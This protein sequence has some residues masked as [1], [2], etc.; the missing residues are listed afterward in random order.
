M[1]KNINMPLVSIIIP[2]YNGERFMRE[3]IDSA[4]A[5]DYENKEIIVVNDGSTDGGATEEIAL[6]YGEA[7]RYFKK[8]N[9][10]VSSALNLGIANM[11][12]EYFSW[13][14]HDDR[15][16]PNKVST[17]MKALLEHDDKSLI[18]LCEIC[19]ID[20][21]SKQLAELRTRKRFPEGIVIGWQEALTEL[22]TY[23]CFNGCALMIPR[24]VFEKCGGFCEELRYAQDWLMWLKIFLEGY[25]LVYTSEV[26]VESRVHA[27]QLTNTG[28][29]LF[30]R[31]SQRISEMLLP[32]LIKK[33]DRENNFLY[34]F[35]CNNARYNNGSVVRDCLKEGI[36]EDLLSF[37][38]EMKIRFLALYGKIR[39]LI[40]KI[41][42]KIVK[43]V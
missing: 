40:R 32:K 1:D 39:P 4:L 37:G 6:S 20:A 9:G 23:G 38:Q 15:Y 25:S 17:T 5:Q 36:A 3:A 41:Y 2:V 34:M 22:F 27:G 28:I 14:S 35:A 10:G 42:Y 29:A 7:I 43:R 19:Q 30:H 26:A 8:E 11:K 13:L 12:G 21:D 24:E 31:D 18:G 16:L 33:S